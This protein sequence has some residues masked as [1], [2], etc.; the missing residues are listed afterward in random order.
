MGSPMAPLH[1][2]LSDLETL[3]SRSLRFRS[4]ISRKEAQLGPML[5]LNINRKPYIMGNPMA[6]SRL[7]LSE[8]ERSN[9]RSP[10]FQSRISQWSFLLHI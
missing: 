7:T 10:R 4:L 6:P 9:S 8:L 2:T 1:L 5:L 3:K